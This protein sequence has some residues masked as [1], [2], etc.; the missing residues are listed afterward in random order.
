MVT[1]Q[2]TKILSYVHKKA[3]INQIIIIHNYI[4]TIYKSTIK[5]TAQAN[6]ESQ[7]SKTKKLGNISCEKKVFQRFFKSCDRM[8][9]LN[10]KW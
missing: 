10:I 6:G 7:T 9:R 4:V 5:T 1:I 2:F 3:I 8:C